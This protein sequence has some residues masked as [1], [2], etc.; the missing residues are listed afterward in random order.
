M[1]RVDAFRK[2]RDVSVFSSDIIGFPLYRYQVEWAQ[3]ILETVEARRNEVLVVKM[4]RQSGKNETSAHLEVRL[5]A[6]FGAKGGEIV[7]CAPTFK[8]QI[9]NSK[10]RF[11]QR[12]KSAQQRLP[13]LKFK[14]TMGYMYRLGKAGI[15]FLSA[16]PNASVVGATASLL[17]EVDEAQDVSPAKFDRDFNP[18][19]ASTGA[20]VA[21]YGTVWTDD[22]LLERFA[23]DVEEGRV[24]GRII[25]VLPE[26]VADENPAYGEFVD[27]EVAR[28]GRN[29]PSV[30]T[31]YFLEPLANRGRML[32]PQQL[33]QMVGD[34]NRKEERGTESAIVAGLDWAGADESASELVS[35]T[36]ASK[37]DSVALTIGMLTWTKVV[38]G[39]ME[40]TVRILARYE[41]T[42]VHPLSMHNT[43]Y[44][45]LQKTWR[46]NRLHADATGIGATGTALLAKAL[47]GE[48]GARVTG[49][50]FDSAWNTQTKL[51]SQ[52]I[53]L[54]NGSRLLD[55]KPGFDPVAVAG[56]DAPDVKDVDRHVWWQRG[57]ARLEA[58]QSERFHAYVPDNEGHDDLL[59]SDMLMVDAA[60]S[61]KPATGV[62]QTTRKAIGY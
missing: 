44:E 52:Y 20:P 56:Q 8:P 34:H 22:T 62:K 12:S 24:A 19:R 13:F 47:D 7:K 32:T 57:H 25:T 59:V 53:A 42:N 45:L 50:T 21:A 60:F 49:I 16:E 39:V 26:V 1:D 46:V 37:R 27:A 38:E 11:D 61:M 48:S 28:L 3:A 54:I 15:S 4:P 55:Y 58:R 5:L 36:T 51:A 35:M 17:L 2:A 23:R 33:R 6:G 14:P 9:V 31:Q 10:L 40:P 18:M 41:W 43:L 30:R 29:H